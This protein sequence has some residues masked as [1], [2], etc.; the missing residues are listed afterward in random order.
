MATGFKVCNT[1][2]CSA[3]ITDLTYQLGGYLSE[4]A[5]SN[6]NLY[7]RKSESVTLDIL[8]KV[9]GNGTVMEGY[10]FTKHEVD[11]AGNLVDEGGVMMTFDSD[12]YYQ[13]THI[14]MPTKKWYNNDED[15]QSY[16]K[17]YIYNEGDGLIYKEVDGNLETDSNQ[18]LLVEEIYEQCDNHIT[19]FRA[20]HDVFNLCY[21]RACLFDAQS[22]YISKKYNVCELSK[23]NDLLFKVNYLTATIQVVTWLLEC[24][25]YEQ[26]MLILDE[27]DTCRGLCNDTRTPADCG[28]GC[29]GGKVTV[30]KTSGCGCGR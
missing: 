15:K 26:A 24:N 5:G 27:I 4:T 2:K 20:T 3:T 28:C 12:G 18:A 17:I 25:D 11:D 1:S 14:I 6:P 9:T 29:R 13:I 19:T 7:F 30:T 10:M 8:M 22:E 16:G 23:D 21:L